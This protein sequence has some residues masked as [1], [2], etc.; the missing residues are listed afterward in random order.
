MVEYK[1]VS[2]WETGRSHLAE[3]RPCQDRVVHRQDRGVTCVVLADGAGS[4]PNGQEGAD[5]VTRL[6]AELLCREFAELW[7]RE[8]DALRRELLERCLR[9][10]EELDRPLPE[11]ASTLLFFA[12]DRQGRYLAGHLGDGI[13][14]LVDPERPSARVFS[15]PE[16]GSYQNETY[17]TTSEDALEHFR[18]YRGRLEEA[19]ALLLMSDGMAE[20]LYQRSTGEPARACITMAGWLRDGEEEIISQALS[21]NMQRVFAEHSSDDLSLGLVTWETAAEEEKKG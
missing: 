20:S 3:D 4:C 12:G 19:G 14:I 21:Q 7:D 15:A 13:Q 2:A 8:E 10:L 17:F 11:L 16:N 5:C 1:A 9:A 18:L 6:L